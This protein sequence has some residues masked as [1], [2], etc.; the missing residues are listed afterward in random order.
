VASLV[1]SDGTR[2]RELVSSQL[3]LAEL[4][5]PITA[6]ENTFAESA[7]S[8]GRRRVRSRP[9]NPVGSFTLNVRGEYLTPDGF[10]DELSG[11]QDLIAAAHRE[12]GTLTYT[13]SD[14]A[15]V[16]YQLEA[17]ALK[18]L[19]QFDYL[20]KQR[21]ALGIVIEFECQPYGLL[22]A[23]TAVTGEVISGPID[24][25][26]VPD[27]P[28]H[29]DAL[30]TLTLTDTVGGGQA[31]HLVEVGWEGGIADPGSEPP[32]VI[33]SDS[34]S[35]VSGGAI[36]GQA[37]SG[38]YDPNASGNSVIRYTTIAAMTVKVATWTTTLKGLRRVNVR[39]YHDGSTST[40]AKVRLGWK[41]SDGPTNYESWQNLSLTA[42]FLDVPLGLVNLV[43]TPEGTH[44][45]TM[46]LEAQH[47]QTGKVIEVDAAF[48]L[49]GKNFIQIRAGEATADQQPVAFDS[50]DTY[51]GGLNLATRAAP[52]G[53]TWQ[54]P[55][56]DA[57]DWLTSDTQ[58]GVRR[59][60]IA[61]DTGT[62]TS[63]GSG[64]A[65]II[66]RLSASAGVAIGAVGRVEAYVSTITSTARV[67]VVMRYLDNNNFLVGFKTL[68]GLAVYKVIGGNPT[69]IL[70]SVAS[71]YV[72]TIALEVD[73]AGRVALYHSP[74]AGTPALEG[75][76]APQTELAT[77][78][79]IGVAAADEFGIFGYSSGTSDEVFVYNFKAEP[80]SSVHP[81]I[82]A[83][84]SLKLRHDSVLTE[85]A[86]GTAF[87]RAPNVHG[88]H[89]RLP[90]ATLNDF[91]TRL[92]IRARRLD[93]TQVLTDDGIA[94]TLSADL[95][96]QPRVLLLD[97]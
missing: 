21:I 35:F 29:V 57:T 5:L 92:V 68:T 74:S 70:S 42:G 63:A 26:D 79:T 51:A 44:S 78:G 27:I 15:A 50:F 12:K 47:P 71:S 33:D 94:D 11:L 24:T 49:P 10:W 86:G 56:G 2:E 30:A 62:I 45:V 80:A 52:L 20:T 8:E 88:N 69:L 18:E 23:Y 13:P 93:T 77:G 39:L 4:A 64:F 38:A 82:N 89:L 22:E 97:G 95:T 31:R 7:D 61:A 54:A 14:G 53:G 67:G 34:M 3:A 32:V 72:G 91:Q 43:E 6:D 55:V 1:L 46:W 84:Q 25:M 40:Q 59:Q 41:V 48:I 87:G 81:A 66:S 83:G 28:G 76:S 60:A 16:T 37:R 96:I 17:V 73:S 9:T 75:V 58:G 90:P 85:N 19:P 36:S 65:G